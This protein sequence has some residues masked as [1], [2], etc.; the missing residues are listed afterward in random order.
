MVGGGRGE[1]GPACP[2]PIAM[3]RREGSD[4]VRLGGVRDL[5]S[6]FR[7]NLGIRFRSGGDGAQSELHRVYSH[8]LISTRPFVWL[9]LEVSRHAVEEVFS[10]FTLSVSIDML[11][12][13]IKQISL[14][15]S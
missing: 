8:G 10:R 3:S 9:D 5:S 11:F 14:Y 12:I 4:L 15:E 6:S 13:L 7:S 1:R 2:P